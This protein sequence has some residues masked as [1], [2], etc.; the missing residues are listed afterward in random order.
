MARPSRCDLHVA[1]VST[2]PPRECG[3]GTLTR[4]LLHGLHTLPQPVA[5]T[6]HSVTPH[7]NALLRSA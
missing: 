5:L 4:D 3:I 1:A 7:P 2:Y 6:M